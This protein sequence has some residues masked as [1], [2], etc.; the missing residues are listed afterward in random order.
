MN[1]VCMHDADSIAV[2]SVASL[3]ETVT[4]NS[5]EDLG[6]LGLGQKYVAEAQSEVDQEQPAS[7]EIIVAVIQEQLASREC[8]STNSSLIQHPISSIILGMFNC[9]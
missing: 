3:H 4:H 8:V 9:I 2:Y 1:I 6:L 5:I 7:L